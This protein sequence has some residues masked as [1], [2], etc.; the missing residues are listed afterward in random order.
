MAAGHFKLDNLCAV[1][2]RN[3][4]EISG[5]TEDVMALE[6][7]ADKWASFGWNVLEAAGNDLD[8]LRAAF[9][10]ARAAKGKPTVV[11][12]KTVK[13]RGVSFMENK[14]GWHHKLPSEAECAAAYEE[15]DAAGRCAE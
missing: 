11:I 14:A 5:S 2:D 9:E 13:G 6:P 1:V 8:A 15:L 7:L 4:L 12:A 10:Q 3:G